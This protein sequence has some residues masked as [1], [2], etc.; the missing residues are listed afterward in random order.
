M[1]IRRLVK[2][3]LIGA[4]ALVCAANPVAGQDHARQA[5]P[6]AKQQPVPIRRIEGLKTPMRDGVVLASD[7]WLP[8]AEG[9]YPVLLM[10]SPYRMRTMKPFVQ[11]AE[12][13]AGHGYAVVIQDARGTGD[14]TGQFDFLFQEDK[15]GYDSIERLA[16]QPWA[17]RR[18]C[19][20]GYSYL[21][22][23]QLLGARERPQHLACIAP[24]AP[25][26]RYHEE[27]PT[28]QGAFMLHWGLN[29]L[30]TW[31]DDTA[32]GP[33][34]KELDWEAALA[35]R[36]LITLDEAVIG[37]KNRLYR[38]FLEND[39]LNDYWRRISFTAQD[40]EK[41]E[42]PMMLTT[43]WFDGDQHGALYYWRGFESRKK[44]RSDVYLTIGPWNHS[45]TFDGGRD[46]MG[47]MPLPADSI[48]DNRARHLAFFDHYL[49]QTGPKPAWARV[50]LFVTGANV[51]RTFD[52][53]PVDDAERRR[54]HLSSSGDANTLSGDGRLTWAKPG[55]EPADEFVYDPRNPVAL[56]FLKGNI[57]GAVR[58][59]A[60]AREDVLVYSTAPL[61]QAVEVIGA[62]TLELHAASDARD[63]DFTAAIS[64]VWPDGKAIVL[65]ARPVGI[66]RARYRNGREAEP[67][68]LTPGKV[69]RYEIDLGSIGHRFLPG[70]SIRVEISSSAAP[71]FNPNQNTGNPI[72][73]DTQWRVANQTVFHDAARPSALI[74]PVYEG[75]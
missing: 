75:G 6:P 26:G 56:N 4:A 33:N 34:Q 69:E 67:T 52:S 9:R 23:V 37:R 62:V 47:A 49:K 28:V 70:H 10:R 5:H 72:A 11:L 73:T 60:Q 35:H 20:L 68:L 66:V 58:N 3:G 16:T 27:M 14:S 21:G 32:R 51:W 61:A 1:F 39:T 45:Q 50:N 55:A 57:F 53:L 43:G 17:N 15:D 40:F 22:S 24:T 38:E 36:P 8:A 30:R 7:I 46:R 13:Y 41:I 71:F 44:P 64:D 18:L 74:L 2:A 59:E 12:F 48:L 54:L 19:M 65:G 63:T 25:A 42:L 31:A 29:W